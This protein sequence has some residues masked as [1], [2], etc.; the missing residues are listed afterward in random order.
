MLGMLANWNG[1]L[2]RR[3][4][5]LVISALVM[6]FLFPLDKSPG[7]SILAVFLFAYMTFVVS[8]DTSL[9]Q[10]FHSL[11]N[12]MLLGWIL[13]LLHGVMPCLAWL[14]GIIFYPHDP[15]IRLGFLVGASVPIGVTSILWTSIAQGDVAIALAAVT[16]DTILCPLILPLYIALV[17]GETMEINYFR[18]LLEL[19]CM[20]T[21]PS[22]LGMWLKDCMGVKLAHFSR[23]W[24]GFTAKVALFF[25]VYI[26]ASVVVPALHWSM[27]LVKLLLVI[28]LLSILGY[29]LG[30]VGSYALRNHSPQNVMS[31]VYSV[32]MR[33]ISFGSVLAVTYFPALV[34]VPVTLGMLYQQPL[35]ALVAFLNK[36][37]GKHPLLDK[38]PG[39]TDMEE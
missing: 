29:G 34:A 37:F 8:M 22:I 15:V 5:V 13:L 12:P 32:G 11:T 10:F 35:A 2:S 38:T 6:G 19:F 31:M 17:A 16:V 3:M 33:N 14:V 23:S 36:R 27:F 18:L 20:V 25:V 24:G 26:N 21:I 4:F 28:F 39:D 7:I 9:K 30:Y 1:W